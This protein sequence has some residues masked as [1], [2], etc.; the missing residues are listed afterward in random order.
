MKF[1]TRKIEDYIVLAKKILDN[2]TE[3]FFK[4]D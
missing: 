3:E 1:I 4:E 2:F